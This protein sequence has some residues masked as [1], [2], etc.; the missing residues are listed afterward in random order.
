[1]IVSRFVDDEDDE[2]VDDWIEK[3]CQ[4]H[5]KII[6]ELAL[7]SIFEKNWMLLIIIIIVVLVVVLYVYRAM[8]V[9]N[10]ISQ[11]NYCFYFYFVGLL[12]LFKLNCNLKS[13]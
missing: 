11:K 12:S 1:M 6:N 13:F 9:R 10:T 7:F 3:Y 8:V 4:L 2:D 5:E